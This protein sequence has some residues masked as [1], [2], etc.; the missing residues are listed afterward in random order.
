MGLLDRLGFGKPSGP[1]IP[2]VVVAGLSGSGR[3]DLINQVIEGLGSGTKVCVVLYDTTHA[4][5]HAVEETDHVAIHAYLQS[6]GG[7]ACHGGGAT[8]V[9][10]SVRKAARETTPNAIILQVGRGKKARE[11]LADLVR[12]GKEVKFVGMTACLRSDSGLN[13]LRDPEDDLVTYVKAAGQILLAHAGG[14]QAWAVE[15]LTK[16]IAELNRQAVVTEDRDQVVR[17]ICAQIRAGESAQA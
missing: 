2:T 11:T 15:A 13:D 12:L 17:S 3:K 10:A 5:C 4:A 14:S 1:P 16:R 7:C 8:P 9:R 6:G